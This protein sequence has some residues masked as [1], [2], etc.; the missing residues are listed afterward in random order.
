MK[1]LIILLFLLSLP[2]IMSAQGFFK[3]VPKNLFSEPTADRTIKGTSVW[4]P[5]PAINLTA[6][7]WN[8]D[9]VTKSFNA[10]AFTSIGLGVGYQHFIDTPNG[11]FN[12]FGF[13]CMMLLGENISG[14]ITFSG[15]GILNFGVTYNLS[16]KQFGLL[17]GVQLKF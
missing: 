15:L 13:N 4:L 8:Y 1:K 9:K 3:P 16:V 5:R 6:V 10:T 14:A 7:Q 17:T 11:P 12:N 2:L